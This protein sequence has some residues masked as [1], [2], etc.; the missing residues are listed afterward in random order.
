MRQERAFDEA[1]VSMRPTGK[2]FEFR[3]DGK[4][5]IEKNPEAPVLLVQ[6]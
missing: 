6:G 5:G 3:L 2:A 1:G 4:R